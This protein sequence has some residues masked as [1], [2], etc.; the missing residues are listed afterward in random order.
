MLLLL[1]QQIEVINNTVDNIEMRH[2]RKY[3]LF[4]GVAEAANENISEVIVTVCQQDMSLPEVTS[5]SILVCHRIGGKAGRP[6]PVLVRFSDYAVKNAVWAK[7][8]A[9]KGTSVVLSEFLTRQRQSLF[10]AAR[11]HFGV[12]SV[13]SLDGNIY[14]K[15]SS[16]KKE[17]VT[18]SDQL[19]ALIAQHPS[20]QSSGDGSAPA[21]APAALPAPAP[22]AA[23]EP[24]SSPALKPASQASMKVPVPKQTHERRA[25]RAPQ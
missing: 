19:Q 21:P 15:V 18:T 9:L 2:R 7:K 1:R 14:I 10:L 22:S 5:N 12:R 8:T 23:G 4:G 3:L 17:R 25:K 11:R 16:G 13:W 6:R 20:E 24:A